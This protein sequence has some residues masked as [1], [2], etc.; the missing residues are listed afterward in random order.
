MS[1][2][3]E[4]SVLAV[5]LMAAALAGGAILSVACGGSAAPS[6][7]APEQ[8]E[9]PAAAEAAPA[10]HEHPYDRG[11]PVATPGTRSPA[12]GGARPA[13]RRARAEEPTEE[14][15][16]GAESPPPAPRPQPQIRTVAAG[17][18]LPVEFLDGVSSRSSQPGDSF[19]ARV[20]GDI[21][22]DDGVVVIPAGSIVKGTVTEAVSLKKIGGTARL[23]LE[24]DRLELPSGE[25]VPIAAAFSQTGKSETAKDAGTIA[26]ATAGG[27]LLGRLLS[28]KDKDKGT[29]IGAVV[30]GAAGTAIAAKTKG[31]EV[32]IPAGTALDIE[33]SEPAKITVFR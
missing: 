26:G 16:A 25:A 5:A 23:A 18:R 24:F 29:V 12:P 11:E 13:P 17:T 31:E 32:E 8:A 7:T 20:T 27:A 10:E 19:R 2:Q 33:L 14:E 28:K 6:R 9:A 30:G 3:P 4:R 1:K 22:A 15:A 21:A